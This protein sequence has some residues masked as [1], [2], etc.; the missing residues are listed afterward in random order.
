ME[1]TKS[2]N[3]PAGPQSSAATNITFRLLVDQIT[4][5]AIFLLT[6]EGDVA[7]WN[8]GA[9]R[10]KGYEPEEIIGR[11]FRTFY[12]SQA[13]DAKIPEQELIVAAAE[14][15]F[16][17]EGWRIRKDGSRF[18]A[19]VIITAIR[20]AS[21]ELVGYGKVTRD[22]TER[23]KAEEQLRELSHYLLK[24]QDE[25][26]GRLGRELHDTVGQYLVA[27]KMSLDG[28]ISETAFDEAQVR[29]RLGETL[30]LVERTVREVRTLSYL[31]YPPMLDEQGLN[32][33]IRWHL[34]GFSKRSGIHTTYEIPADIHLPKDTE[35]ALF[36]VLQESLTNIH[37]HSHSSTAEVRFT[38]AD[39]IAVLE[40]KDQGKGISLE[41]GQLTASSIG[42][43]GVGVR[44]MSERLRQL[45]GTLAITSDSHGTTVKA[46]VPIDRQSA[47]LSSGL[48]ERHPHAD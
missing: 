38:E 35:L 32:A 45:G 37:R 7:T 40:V 12:S 25:E 48:T 34:E 11:H 17:D 30:S 43:L 31:L 9:Q 16:E 18:W 14:G 15:R 36:R 33:A 1:L 41:Q 44:G 21:G 19:N 6:P 27:I 24:M 46:S 13:Q 26:R 47:S 3:F 42:K 5:Y 29:Q 23:K 20:N 10:I 28:L 2:V 22:L 4:D 8:P 39:H